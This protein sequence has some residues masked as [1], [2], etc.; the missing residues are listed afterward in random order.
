[1]K[2]I[3]PEIRIET[4]NRCNGNCVICPR[5]K[6]TRPIVTMDSAQFTYLI[7][8][9]RDL[10]AKVVSPFGFGEPLMDTDIVENIRA[11]TVL[12]LKTF[13]TTNASLLTVDLAH[14]LL[15]ARL[16]KIRFSMHGRGINYE[17]VHR[18]FD[19]VEVMRNINTFLKINE[20]RHENACVTAVTVI[21]MHGERIE[22]IRDF[23]QGKVDEVEIWRPH[24]FSVGKDYRQGKRVKKTCGRPHSGPVQIQAD[25]LMVACCFDFN[26]EL[27]LGD[28]HKESIED[29]LKGAKYNELRKRHETG[30]L[31]GLICESCDQLFKYDKS[32]LLYSS[33]DESREI[34]K[35]SSTKF[36]LKEM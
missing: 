24:N 3:N 25:G 4:T 11:C 17:L 6:M 1:M 8:Q 19:F 14:D 21:P 22:D 9:A 15:N 12:R 23:W 35:T 10:G 20:T 2:L 26:G 30:D 33:V 28:T 5:D 16:S 18:N 31:A 27:V 29:I 32:P 13:I 34:G 36:K 7:V